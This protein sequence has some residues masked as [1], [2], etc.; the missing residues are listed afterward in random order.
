M[1][2]TL[3]TAPAVLPILLDQ[4]KDH[5]KVST[6]DEDAYIGGLIS[7]ATAQL[8]GWAGVLGRAMIMQTWDLT[9]P[10]F[11]D[12]LR[13][14]LP[15]TISVDTITY[16]DTAGASQTLGAG[17]WTLVSGG[18]GKS[19]LVRDIDQSFPSTRTQDDAVTVQFTAGYGPSWN[20]VPPTLRHAMLFL[21]AHYYEERQIVG[22]GGLAKIP[23][24]ADALITPHRMVGF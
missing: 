22:P 19:E 2:L 7:V 10:A 3:V 5:L 4:A 1:N 24:A 20:D 16:I 13:L 8:D 15:P 17:I 6:N 14:P 12:R 11:C 21:I 9:L 18:T 23:D